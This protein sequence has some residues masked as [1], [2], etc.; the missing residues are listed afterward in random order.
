VRPSVGRGSRARGARARSRAGRRTPRHYCSARPSPPL[1]PR[2]H[3]HKALEYASTVAEPPSGSSSAEGT[4]FEL[5]YNYACAAIWTEDLGLAKRLL[6]RAI[7]LCRETLSGD[8]YTEEEV[9]VTSN[10][11][12]RPSGNVH[13]EEE[14]E[15]EPN[16]Y[17]STDL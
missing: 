2:L 9:E 17:P 1:S 10:P 7:E 15:V 11:N 8:D 16:L 14:V 3:S 13:T 4:Q 6:R 5:Y 12:P